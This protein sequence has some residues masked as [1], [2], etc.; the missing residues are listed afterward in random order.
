MRESHW[1][2]S[3]IISASIAKAANK[4]LEGL[5]GLPGLLKQGEL[6][7]KKIVIILCIGSLIA[8]GGG[9]GGGD[10]DSTPDFSGVWDVSLTLTRDTC[11]LFELPPQ[12]TDVLTVNQTV[13]DVTVGFA[14]G[15]VSAGNVDSNDSFTVRQTMNLGAECSGIETTM[16]SSLDGNAAEVSDIADIQCGETLCQIEYGSGTAVRR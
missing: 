13:S 7:M 14:D 10:D 8:C 16:F 9:G 1:V 4:G 12:E 6:N 15:S 11:R 3:R 5:A 2:D